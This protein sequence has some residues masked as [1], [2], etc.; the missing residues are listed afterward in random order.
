M[1]AFAAV[2]LLLLTSGRSDDRAVSLGAFFFLLATPFTNRSLVAAAESSASLWSWIALLLYALPA[3]AF[4]AY[5]FW[6]FAQDFPD[7]VSSFKVQR[8]LS[9]GRK[10]ALGVGFAGFAWQ[11]ARL[12][13]RAAEGAATPAALAPP[14]PSY[15][16]YGPLLLLVTLALGVLLWRTRGAAGDEGR[17]ARLFVGALVLGLAPLFLQI[18]LEMAI[19]PYRELMDVG[20]RRT[21]VSQALLFPCLLSVLLTTTYSV[22]VAH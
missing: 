7:R 6:S 13:A 21:V 8:L 16:Y 12:L 17:R 20:N 5:F 11:I 2:G 14:K 22:L 1:L 10:T 3:D 19:R 4:L 18:V 9:L 15:E